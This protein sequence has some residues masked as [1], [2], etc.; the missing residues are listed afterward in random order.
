[1]EEGCVGARTGLRGT[2]LLNQFAVD[3]YGRMVHRGGNICNA[4]TRGVKLS[5][6]IHKAVLALPVVT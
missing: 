6:N 3:F 1:V 4:D 2:G 5:M